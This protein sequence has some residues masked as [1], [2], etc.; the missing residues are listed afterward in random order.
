MD[1]L[2]KVH[3]IKKKLWGSIVFGAGIS[4]FYADFIGKAFDMSSCLS[5]WGRG[6]A[7]NLLTV[8]T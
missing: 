5:R 3:Y 2:K 7:E 4:G 1:W 8:F 6:V